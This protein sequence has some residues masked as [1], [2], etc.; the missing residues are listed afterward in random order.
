MKHFRYLMVLMALLVSSTVFAQKQNLSGKVIDVNGEPVIGATV[1]EKGTTNGAATDIDGM[2]TISVEPGATLTF[3]YVGYAAQELRASNNMVVTLKEDAQ[4]LND[5]VVIGYGTQKKSIVTASIAKVDASDLENKSVVRMDNALKGLA[6]GV[7]VTSS[8][9]QPGAAARIRVR[10]TGTI[11]NSDPLYIVDGMP[12]EGGLDFVNPNDIES[13]EVLK[14]AASG[15]IYGA[16]AANGVI[17]VT[18][19]KGKQGR[20]N[21]NY[22]FSAG[23]QSAWKRRDVLN[24]TDYAILQ[25]EQYINSGQNALY[26][27][28]Y[29][30]GK[31]TDWQDLVFNDGAPVVNHDLSVSGATEKLNYYLSLGYYTQEG[32]VGGNFDQSNYQRLSMRSNTNYN[33]FDDTDKRNW[34]NKLD[35]TVN[36]S[37]A[38]IKSSG[39]DVN[40]QWG[41]VLGSSLALSPILTPTVSGAEAL[42]Q[43]QR[44]VYQTYGETGMVNNYYDPI[45]DRNGNILMIPGTAYN[46]INNPLA[47]MALPASKGWSHKFVS[48]FAAELNIWDALKYRFSYSADL[49]FWGS[50]SYTPQTYYRSANNLA[51]YTNTFAESDRGTVWQIEN[52]LSYDKT[53]GKHHF[54]V[55]LGQSAFKN[56]GFGINGNRRGMINPDKPSINYSTGEY[57]TTYQVDGD[58][59]YI[60]VYT[61]DA[62]GNYVPAG[63]Q[64][65]GAVVEHGVAGWINSPHTMSSLFFRGSYDYDERYMAQFTIRRDGSSRFGSN[66][67]YGTFPSVSLGWNVMN[68]AFMENTR[69]WLSNFKARFSWGKNGNDNIGDFRYTVLTA[70]GN[71]YYFGTNSTLTLGS[72]ANALPNPDLKWE[73]SEQTNF[74]L[75]FGFFNNALTLSMDYFSKKTNGMLMTMNIPSY[76]GEAKPIGNVGDMEN[77]GFEVELGYKWRVNDFRFNARANASYLHNEL[78]EYGNEAGYADLDSFQGVGTITRAENGL[79]FPFFYGFKTDGIFQNMDEVRSYTNADGN[80]IQPNAVP[81]DVRFQDLNGDGAITND[82]RTNIGNGT[83]KWTFGLNFGAEWKGFDFNM[84][85]QGVAGV[86]V[87]DATHRTDIASSNYPSWMLQRWTGEGTS[88]RIPRL[89]NGD[90]NNWQSSDLYI[91]D[92]SYLRLKN[93]SFGYTL[94]QYLTQK[95]F[96]Q[97][98][99]LFVMAEN[100]ITWTKYHGFDPEISSGGTSLGV[101]YGVYPQARTWTVGFNITL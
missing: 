22:N 5:V 14:D 68:E 80:M 73:E 97:R 33:L 52:V 37:Y 96:V 32:I 28:P 11:N 51:Q 89:V 94:P 72:K 21:I 63:Y 40:S 42:A 17:L 88:T 29:S 59:K 90:A 76:V 81:G 58:G 93:I 38:R 43:N 24:A 78:L 31:G 60:P 56:T 99:R 34:L 36:L 86:D 4:M 41:S 83:P 77:S 71:N 12:I 101:D 9:G 18:T 47:M 100:L 7:N 23:W 19:K 1:M 2:F 54:A 10:G 35:L 87:F 79:P 82:D 64:V 75:D 98:L 48:N 44:Y 15:A 61:K 85:W 74:G 66:N 67:K 46:E 49:S 53:I 57:Q 26:A 30:L 70:T 55:V 16:R 84:F 65:T 20:A 25:N 50:D 3:S 91:Y 92:G 95:F 39:I 45:Y 13:I 6:A 27:D 8:S 69:E 62:A